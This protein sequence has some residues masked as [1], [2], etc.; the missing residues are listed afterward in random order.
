MENTTATNSN[1]LLEKSLVPVCKGYDDLC[2]ATWYE[3]IIFLV[4]IV[5]III[6]I[7]HIVILRRIATRSS[8]GT[9]NSPS[10]YHKLIVLVSVVDILCAAVNMI[11][12]SCR[13]H[14]LLSQAPQWIS[15]AVLIA[16]DAVLM[17]RYPLLIIACAERYVALCYAMR[18]AAKIFRRYLNLWLLIGFI[19]MTA[20]YITRALTSHICVHPVVGV[21][22][23]SQASLI[24]FLL[25][26]LIPLAMAT[27]LIALSIA[28]MRK[29]QKKTVT[30]EDEQFIRNSTIYIIIISVAFYLCF[31]PAIV[32]LL[33]KVVG[34]IETEYTA[35]VVNI[36]TS[37]YGIV[38]TLI[39]GWK[40]KRY[41]EELSLVLGKK[42]TSM[43][44]TCTG[45]S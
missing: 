42:P 6:N 25:S 43:D 15:V 29:M 32:S 39:Y 19:I 11:K 18:P 16:E 30:S 38:N 31:I 23:K 45:S 35:M 13:L 4:N 24:I 21:M 3:A 36:V 27:V 12:V 8:G 26:I 5:S 7:L 10:A 1:T 20:L 34:K 44:S 9:H 41:R 40:H 2:T 37:L 14:H 17:Y 33:V 22:G 28:E